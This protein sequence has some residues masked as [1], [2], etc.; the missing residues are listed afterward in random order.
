MNS[1]EAFNWPDGDVILRSTDGSD[2]R[3]FRL[4]KLILSLASPAFRDMFSLPRPSS[5][6]L[7]FDIIDVEDPPRAVELTL[8]FIYPCPPPK[9]DD[10][11]L[12]SEALAFADNY[13]IE[14]ARSQLRPS[15]MA[16]AETESL[17]V[18]AIAC[19]F[20]FVEEM[21][22]ASSYTTSIHLPGLAKLP[23]EFR[24]IP[25]AEY[26]RLTLLHAR[27]RKEFEAIALS[28]RVWFSDSPTFFGKVVGAIKLKYALPIIMGGTPLNYESLALAWTR[29]YG[30]DADT[31]GVGKIFRSFLD[32]VNALNLTV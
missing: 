28:G 6:P 21:K 29:E 3:D 8:R 2:S 15:L 32:K 12:L 25:A 5:P 16:F 31:S 26:D 14:S 7:D 4:H 19:R 27:Y 24:F 22:R 9:I 10:L 23:D 13:D 17:R 18:Y 20:G 30:V 11:T 1:E